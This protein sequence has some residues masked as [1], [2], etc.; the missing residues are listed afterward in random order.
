[1]DEQNELPT[2]YESIDILYNDD[3]NKI[4]YLKILKS[5]KIVRN[6][7]KALKSITDDEAL[8]HLYK[9]VSVACNRVCCMTDELGIALDTLFLISYPD[10]EMPKEKLIERV[11]KEIDEM[12][13]P[14]LS[15]FSIDDSCITSC[16]YT[17]EMKKRDYDNICACRRY[18]ATIKDPKI[19][20]ALQ[21]AL[22]LAKEEMEEYME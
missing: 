3:F 1:M 2:V 21:N 15:R 7:Y 20:V 9:M 6:G 22:I 13:G 18:I 5:D 4:E 19:K 17:D 12:G 14:P 8:E 16:S 11:K 10:L